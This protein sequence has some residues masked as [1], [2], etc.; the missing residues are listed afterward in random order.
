LNITA[1]TTFEQLRSDYY[2]Q[3]K[4]LVEGG[5]DFLLM[6]TCFDTGSLKAGLVAIQQLRH[7][8]GYDIPAIASVTIEATGTMSGGQQIDALYASIE[9]QDLLAAGMN[10]ATGP[11]LMTDQLPSLQ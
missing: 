8:L 3:A 9:S 4:G 11:D 2:E 10:S 5:S 1:T 7:D 6:E